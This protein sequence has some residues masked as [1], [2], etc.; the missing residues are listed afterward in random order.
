[1]DNTLK[2]SAIF[3][4]IDLSAS[5]TYF[6]TT[7]KKL[8]YYWLESTSTNPPLF[9]YSEFVQNWLEGRKQSKIQHIL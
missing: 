6:L 7:L 5:S 3:T 9:C 2:K 4:Y 8:L 1:M